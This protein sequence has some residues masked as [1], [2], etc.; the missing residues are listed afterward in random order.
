MINSQTSKLELELN[1]LI[2]ELKRNEGDPETSCRLNKD[3]RDVFNRLRTKIQV[4]RNRNIQYIYG[5][6]LY[7]Q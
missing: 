5:K 4:R 7:F 6:T 2:D 3:I 1:S